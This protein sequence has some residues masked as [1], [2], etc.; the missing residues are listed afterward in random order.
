MTAFDAGEG[1]GDGDIDANDKPEECGLGGT[2]CQDK[3]VPAAGS[4]SE[5]SC[6]GDNGG[7]DDSLS[8]GCDDTAATAA[9]P[10]CRTSMTPSPLYRGSQGCAVTTAATTVRAT[11]GPAGMMMMILPPSYLYP[12]PNNAVA[13]IEGSLIGDGMEN[14]IRERAG[15]FFSAESLATHLWGRS[16]QGQGHGHG[17]S[18]NGPKS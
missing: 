16:W 11:T 18:K 2:A 8:A 6:S 4:G 14:G 17:Q 12:I 13:A 5:S 1:D 9:E 7:G 10:P 15:D 3:G